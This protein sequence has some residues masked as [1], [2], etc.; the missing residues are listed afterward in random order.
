MHCLQELS[1]HAPALGQACC[2]VP[3]AGALEPLASLE[4]LYF[5]SAHILSAK[6]SLERETR[7]AVAEANVDHITLLPLNSQ[8]GRAL[9]PTLQ[10]GGPGRAGRD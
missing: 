4:S 8:E 5:S 2:A 3:R 9:N 6:A 1:L 7:S 10:D